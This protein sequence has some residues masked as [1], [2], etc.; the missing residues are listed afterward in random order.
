M[1]A[2]RPSQCVW[3]DKTSPPMSPSHLLAPQCGFTTDTVSLLWHKSTELIASVYV[4]MEIGFEQASQLV[5]E[6]AGSASVC[7]RILNPRYGTIANINYGLTFQTQQNGAPNGKPLTRRWWKS[8][9]NMYRGTNF[10]WLPASYA[11]SH[12]LLQQQTSVRQRPHHSWSWSRS[13]GNIHCH[14]DT[15]TFTPFLRH[16]QP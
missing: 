15:T 12:S 9:F 8:F 2:P 1:R 5:R 14:S 6:D 7:L 13:D 10:S 3:Q 16:H 11:T 4:E